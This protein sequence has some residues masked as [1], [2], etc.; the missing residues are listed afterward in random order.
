MSSE[1]HSQTA[2]D[3]E[4]GPQH[5][6]LPYAAERHPALMKLG[7]MPAC[8]MGRPVEAAIRESLESRPDASLPWAHPNRE[9]RLLEVNDPTG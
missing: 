6:P 5:D 4:I 1:C 9:S 3:V 8:R 7:D 2:A